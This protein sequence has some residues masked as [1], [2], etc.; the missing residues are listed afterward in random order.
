MKV[1]KY[2]ES[3]LKDSPRDVDIKF[4]IGVRV[5]KEGLEVDD[6]SLNRVRFT[7]TNIKQ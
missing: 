1:G 6:L 4:D 5:G 3:I 2:I 7:V